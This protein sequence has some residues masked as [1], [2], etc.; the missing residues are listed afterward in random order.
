MDILQFK[1]WLEDAGITPALNT[2][3][4]GPYEDKI[5]SNNT[6]KSN[7][8]EPNDDI[9]RK[10]REKAA[11]EQEAFGGISTLLRMKKMKKK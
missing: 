2:N 8:T 5:N 7:P 3:A 4:G 1:M 9:E 11:K 10:N 6:A